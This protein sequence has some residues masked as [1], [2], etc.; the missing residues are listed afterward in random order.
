MAEAERSGIALNCED[1]GWPVASDVEPGPKKDGTGTD[2][3]PSVEAV[4]DSEVV[5]EATASKAEVEKLHDGQ[6]DVHSE[7][8]TVLSTE[9]AAAK[10]KGSAKKSKSS[11]RK[12]RSGGTVTTSKTPKAKR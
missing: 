9:K 7:V 5:T 4:I 2:D 10:K 8:K 1:S 3:N 11:S 6:T 12:K